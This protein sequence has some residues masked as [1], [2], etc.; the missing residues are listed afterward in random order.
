M[1]QINLKFLSLKQI[2]TGPTFKEFLLFLIKNYKSGQRFDE[3][4][5]PIYT[6]CTPCS[7]NYT[8]IAK[9]ETFQRDS[10]YII[11]QAGLE[12]LLLDKLPH[13]KIKSITNQS[14]GETKNYIER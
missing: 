2:T 3:H 14:S 12:T 7:I 8:L 11:R 10:E 4:W 9:M 5:S 1:K 13:K 6:F